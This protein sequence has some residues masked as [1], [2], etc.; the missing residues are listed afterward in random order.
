M[1]RGLPGQ[2]GD[3]G[4][5]LHRGARK[6]RPAVLAVSDDPSSV[7]INCSGE[8]ATVTGDMNQNTNVD[9]AAKGEAPN[10]EATTNPQLSR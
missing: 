7:G 1:Q 10:P 9:V 2:D 6:H 5:S 4:G 8:G 3:S